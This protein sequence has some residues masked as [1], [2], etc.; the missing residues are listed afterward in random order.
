MLCVQGMERLNDGVPR[1]IDACR[2]YIFEVI[3]EA[4]AAAA[5]AGA[6]AAGGA[7]AA[8]AAESAASLGVYAGGGLVSQ[9]KVPFKVTFAPLSVRLEAPLSADD[10]MGMLITPD[11]SNWMRSEQMHAAFAGLHA[12]AAAHGGAMPPARDAAAA[13]EVAAAAKAF[14]AGLKGKDG[15]LQLEE[16]DEALVARVASLAAYELP[17]LS[18]FLSGVLAQELV[19]LTGKFTPLRQF[20]YY[21]ALGAL[22]S[23]EDEA[24]ALAANP[25]E[26]MSLGGADARYDSIVGLLGRTMQ[27][28]LAR[29]RVFLVGAGAVGCE[30]LKNL[31]ALGVGSGGLVTVTDMDRIETSNLSR[32]FLYRGRHVGAPKSVTS[33]AE[34]C[35]M[36]PGFRAVALQA[37]VG[38]ATE[39]IFSD[40]FFGDQDIVI[41]ALDN[42]EARKYVDRRCVEARKPLL[43]CGT[44]GTKANSQVR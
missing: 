8:P 2:S 26:F 10:P 14:A 15:C 38:D 3:L 19:K 40:A 41:N 22:A 31:G 35:R 43:E 30:Q 12:Y 29:Q 39:A 27:A 36:Y 1:R 32:Q 7:G 17:P 16:V 21:D 42:V 37:P 5:D 13:A 18:T 44:L 33:V 24:A 28:K 9:Q 20:L 11:M 23:V 4:P 34:I 25:D 6:G